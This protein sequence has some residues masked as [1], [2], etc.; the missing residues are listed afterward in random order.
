MSLFTAVL[1][2]HFV[3]D[4]LLQSKKMALNKAN[5]GW[6]GRGW[7]A[8]HCLIYTVTVCVFLRDF[9]PVL[10]TLVWLTHWPLDRWQLTSKWLNL[11]GARTLEAAYL[12]K[13][14]FR[15]IDLSF[16]CIVYTV[17]DTT[18]HLLLLWLVVNNLEFFKSLF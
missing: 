16:T 15:E 17:A 11:I 18:I 7:C 14:Q 6:A 12:S 13:D 9:S 5:P 2:G 4:F 8:L 1:F 3:G 10:L